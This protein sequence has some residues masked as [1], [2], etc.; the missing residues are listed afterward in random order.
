MMKHRVAHD[1]VK[2]LARERKLLGIAQQEVDR[3]RQLTLGRSLYEFTNQ[4]KRC[5][6]G[7]APSN[8]GGVLPGTAA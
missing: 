2:G 6:G 4:V 8:L 5:E 3:A 7:A 1:R